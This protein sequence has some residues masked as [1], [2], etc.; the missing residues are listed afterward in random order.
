VHLHLLHL[1]IDEEVTGY[2]ELS[3]LRNDLLQQQ[4][5]GQTPGFHLSG[6]D[7]D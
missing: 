5:Y 3:D 7:P 2:G 1:F 4:R 6:N